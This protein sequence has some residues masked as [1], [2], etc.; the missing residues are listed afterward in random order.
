MLIWINPAWL[1]TIPVLGPSINLLAGSDAGSSVSSG[2]S[3]GGGWRA[4]PDTFTPLYPISFFMSRLTG[5]AAYFL[6][7]ELRFAWLESQRGRENADR[8]CG[9][10]EIA[11]ARKLYS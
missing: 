4:R 8:W 1:S 6:R 2:V 10:S 7:Y 5:P 11:I 9:E 3:S